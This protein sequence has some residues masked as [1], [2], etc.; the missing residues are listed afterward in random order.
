MN[1]RKSTYKKIISFLLTAAGVV[2]I[3]LL[4]LGAMEFKRSET[5]IQR[6]IDARFTEAIHE[7]V[8]LKMEGVY[9]HTSFTNNPATKKERIKKQTIIT[10]D[11]TIIRER[12]ISDNKQLELIK[13]S[14]SYLLL[15]NRLRPDTLQQLFDA[16]LNENN[17]KARSFALVR[18]GDSAMM[19]ADTTG[20]RVNYRVPVVKGGVFDEISYEGLLSYS[21]LAVFRL[22][23]KTPLVVLFILELLILGLIV[24]MYRRLKLIRPDQIVKR[25]AFYYIGELILNTRTGELLSDRGKGKL[26][27]QQLGIL[28]MLIENENNLVLKDNIKN[29]YWSKTTR[30]E[31]NMA[32]T[33][34]K[35]RAE[36][37]KVGCTFNIP[38]IKG[39]DYYNLKYI[40][41]ES[42]LP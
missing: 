42:T 13:S 37:E 38:K 16:K 25:G 33:I 15:V 4:L 22:I 24:Y 1:Y 27:S 36:L 21:S 29:T 18:Y 32:S 11:T 3:S 23:P 17:I 28:L 12:E 10:K 5:W 26:P 9:R 34:S 35:L 39:S 31:E 2:L 40:D 6:E 19:S 7:E 8:E 30:A 20:Y 41:K 14:Q